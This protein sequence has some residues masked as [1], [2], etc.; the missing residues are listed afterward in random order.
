MV[1]KKASGG[2]AIVEVVLLFMVTAAVFVALVVYD[3]KAAFFVFVLLYGIYPRFFSLGISEA[4]LALSMQ[5]AALLLLLGMY[6]LHA[7]WGSTD[8]QAGWRL[9]ARQRVFLAALVVYLVAR[10]AGNIAAGRLDITVVGQVISE[11]LISIFVVV[12]TV[13]YVKTRRDISALLLVLMLSLLFN[14]LIA[15]YEFVTQQPI[16]PADLGLLYDAGIRGEAV[17][18]GRMRDSVFRVMGIFDN[19]LKLAVFLSMLLPFAVFLTVSATKDWVKTFAAAAV[20][21]ALPVAWFTGSRAGIG[22]VILVF[23]WQLY[24]WLGARMTAWARK[25]LL[26]CGFGFAAFLAYAFAGQLI[27]ELLFGD[28]YA[29]STQARFDAYVTVPLLLAESPWFGFGYA[30]NIVE[31]LDLGSLDP[32]YMRLALEG[33]IVSVTAFVVFIVRAISIPAA[34]VTGESLAVDVSLARAIRMSLTIAALLAL[35]L[36][37]A[38]TRMYVFLFAGLAVALTGLYSTESTVANSQD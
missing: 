1:C 7:L 2:L 21:L 33:G 32:F 36:T 4:G 5:R 13:T 19:P 10:L 3:I 37:L 34:I 18:E 20:I 6:S 35:I 17:L 14:Q 27:Q 23:G 26:V 8:V 25:L 11:S 24:F 38:Y 30:R 16:F 31:Q 29:R 12:L 9:L 22:G 15:T 28:A